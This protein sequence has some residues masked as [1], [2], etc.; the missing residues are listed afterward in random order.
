MKS[1]WHYANPRAQ[2]SNTLECA[3][4][5]QSSSNRKTSPFW[6]EVLEQDSKIP[7]LLPTS[8]RLP[9]EWMALPTQRT[10]LPPLSSLAHSSLWKHLPSHSEVRLA[11]SLGILNLIQP[12]SSYVAI[13][14][15]HKLCAKASS[16][17]YCVWKIRVL[18]DLAF[19][20]FPSAHRCCSPSLSSQISMSNLPFFFFIKTPITLDHSMPQ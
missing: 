2:M 3:L 15:C 12:T 6:K 8:L 20:A 19:G 1:K 5:F 4:G 10:N 16:H 9:R 17:F 11:N 7:T 13:A 18:V 14:K